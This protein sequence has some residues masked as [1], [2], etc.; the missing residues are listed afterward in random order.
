MAIGR[1]AAPA[2][3]FRV[4]KSPDGGHLVLEGIVGAAQAAA[5]RETARELA[6][7]GRPVKVDVS[8]LRHVDCAGVQVL[9]ALDETLR[10]QG[11]SLVLVSVPGSVGATLRN[12]GLQ[13]L[14]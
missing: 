4:E 7:T 5:L 10:R 3:P 9:L 6:A 12:A 2:L 11:Q 1:S 8:G 13:H 14:A